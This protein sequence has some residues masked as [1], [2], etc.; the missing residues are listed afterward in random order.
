M[1][2]TLFNIAVM[3]IT[4]TMAIG[5]TANNQTPADHTVF[6][7]GIAITDTSKVSRQMLPWKMRDGRLWWHGSDGLYL[8]D[9][10][11]WQKFTLPEG[12]S[13]NYIS[14][15]MQ[16]RNGSAWFAGS[17]KGRPIIANFIEKTWR[18]WDS[19]TG[20]GEHGVGSKF[21]ED[22]DGGIWIRTSNK[23]IKARGGVDRVKGGNGVLHF[24]GKTWHNYTVADGLI[25]NR[26]YDVEPDPKGGVWI[27]TLRGLSHYKDGKWI[28]HLV[29]SIPVEE[30][31]NA[32]VYEGRKIY[33][34]FYDQKGTLWAAHGSHLGRTIT[35]CR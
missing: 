3:F 33:E 1:N 13:L 18:I 9:G 28:S 25:H 8:Q 29:D 11:M 23:D 21:A 19:K 6:E 31:R 17:Y 22:I 14:A 7:G 12:G 4:G 26:V 2:N 35:R 27:A 30:I 16:A 5:C 32:H 10:D 24:D 34:L 15:F 20:L